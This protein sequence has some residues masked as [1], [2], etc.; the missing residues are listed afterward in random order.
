MERPDDT[1]TAGRCELHLPSGTFFHSDRS[2][3]SRR[4]ADVH[5]YPDA[6]REQQTHGD[7]PC[8]DDRPRP[9]RSRDH[10]LIPCLDEHALPYRLRV[11]ASQAAFVLEWI[12]VNQI[13]L[14][15]HHL[16]SSLLTATASSRRPR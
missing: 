2:G 10:W 11:P 12:A 4:A 6:D 14:H 5:A 9:P 7:G 3:G 8:D 13:A 1:R 15:I 16:V